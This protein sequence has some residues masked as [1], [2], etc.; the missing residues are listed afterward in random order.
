MVRVAAT[1]ARPHIDRMSHVT[2]G[3]TIELSY[4]S[5]NEMVDEIED[6][7]REDGLFIPTHEPIPKGTRRAVRIQVP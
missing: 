7:L 5:P 2:V 3:S 1:L 6:A 4:M